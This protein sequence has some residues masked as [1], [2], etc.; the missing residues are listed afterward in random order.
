[1]S[2]YS[3]AQRTT[4]TTVNTPSWEIRSAATNKPR[5]I[6][7]GLSQNT[8]VAGVYGLG[9]PGSI[10]VTPTT[11][12]TFVREGDAGAPTGLTTAAVAWG[13]APTS[14]TNFDRR[15][16]PAGTI[17]AGVIWTFPR[18][19]EMAV[20]SSIVIWLLQTSPVLDVWAVLDE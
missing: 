9:R 1:M 7:V 3:L 20:S 19:F 10:G 14:P 5:V 17:G 15:A 13:T 12:Q 16:S 4:A 11:P 18:G 8:A 2:F 6:E